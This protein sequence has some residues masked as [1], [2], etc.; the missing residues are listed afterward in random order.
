MQK[1]LPTAEH[2]NAFKT[3]CEQCQVVLRPLPSTPSSLISDVHTVT[4]DK[5]G[6]IPACITASCTAIHSMKAPAATKGGMLCEICKM[7][8][9]IIHRSLLHNPYRFVV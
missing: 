8:N 9:S 7:Y 5:S 4:A 6:S 1:P 3:C 2:E